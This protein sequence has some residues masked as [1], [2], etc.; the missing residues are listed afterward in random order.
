MASL[1]AGWWF[2]VNKATT[3]YPASSAK[4][5]LV[6]TMGG[7]VDVAGGEAPAT[8]PM[9]H[10]IEGK[11]L[12]EV[13]FLGLELFTP[14][15]AVNTL[16]LLDWDEVEIDRIPIGQHATLLGNL[17]PPN[18]LARVIDAG[19]GLGARLLAADGDVKVFWTWG[20]Q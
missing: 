8:S 10:G 16:V 14:P 5:P 13:I 2:R 17:V 7:S 18:V 9:R 1:K 3:Q 4:D 15:A 6:P 11:P 12:R 19:R 20:P